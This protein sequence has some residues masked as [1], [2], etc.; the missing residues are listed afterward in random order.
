MWNHK[1]LIIWQINK[2]QFAHC[3][4][5]W[6]LVQLNKYAFTAMQQTEFKYLNKYA[7]IAMHQAEFLF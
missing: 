4:Y 2:R 3:E 1:L 7:F 6:H 5:E